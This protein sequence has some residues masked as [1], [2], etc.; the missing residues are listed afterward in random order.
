MPKTQLIKKTIGQ[1]GFDFISSHANIDEATVLATLSIFNIENIENIQNSIVNLKRINDIKK[2]NNFI[3]EINK[4]LNLNGTYIGC[5]ETYMVR[6]HRIM[7]KYPKP[8]N[9]IYYFFDFILTRIFPKIWLTSRIYFYLSGGKGRVLSKTEVLGRLVYCGFGIAEVKEINNLLFFAVKKVSEPQFE[10][11]RLKYGFLIK[12]PRIGKNGKIIRV[13]KLRTM[14]AYSEYIQQYVF[15]QNS[16]A[17]GGKL[18]DDFRISTYGAKFRKYWIDEIPMIINLL[19]G[20][21]KI[22]GVRPLSKHYMS[23]YSDELKHLRIKTKPG[24]LP[25]FYVDMPKDLPEIMASEEK[26]LHAYLKNPIKTDIKY[27]FKIIQNILLRGKR[28]A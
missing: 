28:S 13:Y 6:K 8:F 7:Q 17:E 27:F 26:Y 12:L 14:H 20:E 10:D 3:K 9:H 22:I 19:R 11:T 2:L 15:E 1:Q 16:L 21:M 5:V 25:P 4:K 23:L 18:K 24:R